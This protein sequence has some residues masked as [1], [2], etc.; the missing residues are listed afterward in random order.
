MENIYF[1]DWVEV[2][3]E[4]ELPVKVRS[5][6]R[7]TIGWYLGYCRRSRAGV[8]FDSAREFIAWAEKEKRAEPWQLEGWKEAIR[9][10]F[11][12]AKRGKAE[13]EAR[14]SG[15]VVGS[16]AAG[17]TIAGSVESGVSLRKSKSL[18][19][20]EWKSRFL[21]VIRRRHYSFRTEQSYLVWIEQ[22]ARQM[23][24]TDLESLG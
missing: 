21:T 8:N 19:M 5:S 3:E 23:E 17:R 16:D 9:W 10:F 4:A 7:I 12:E 1:H 11:R 13:F 24:R 22:Y 15:A 20:P 14:S 2:L 18:P 6:W